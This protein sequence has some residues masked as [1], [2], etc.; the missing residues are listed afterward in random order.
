MNLLLRATLF[1]L[2]AVSVMLVFGSAIRTVILP[3]GIPAKLSRW[4][5][6]AVRTFLGLRLGPK[7]EYEKRDRIMA[8]YGPLGLMTLLATWLV[9]VLFGYALMFWGL[10]GGSPKLAF[11]LSGSSLFTLG[12]AGAQDLPRLLLSFSEAALGLVL[13]ALL[14]TYL[15]SIYGAFSRRE[16]EVAKLEVRA[17]SP[18]TGLEMIERASRLGRIDRLT[19]VWVA[20]EDWF[21]DLEESHTSL[22]VL[23]FFRSPQPERS[24]VTAA[25]AVLD[26]ASLV[27]STVDQP[28]NIE[29]EL[30]VRAGYVALRRIAD[31]FEIPYDP[32][33]SPADPISIRR[34]E[35]DEVYERFKSG[36][37]PV[38]EQEA[39]WKSFQGWRV[40]YDSVLIALA[41]LT[42]APPAP[43]SSDR[44]TQFRFPIKGAPAGIR[45]PGKGGTANS[46]RSS[47]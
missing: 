29:S 12:F 6:L 32:F 26:G 37:V 9:I 21:A 41:A 44:S 30:C 15:P 3:R 28:R 42:L 16:L 23:A 2:G 43:W 24:W 5:M 35:F 47:N 36:G 17:G 31:F 33:P 20:W 4:V 14:I 27:S 11:S 7:T 45:R 19:D 38:K 10:Q 34:E 40:N 8:L 18:P 39:A 1:L 22:P 13:L 46:S 25:G